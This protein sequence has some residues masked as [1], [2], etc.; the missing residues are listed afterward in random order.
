MSPMAKRWTM[1]EI[2]FL[3]K[4]KQMNLKE[5]MLNLPKRT[6]NSIKLKSMELF[7]PEIL[8]KNKEDVIEDYVNKKHGIKYIAKKYNVGATCLLH[9]LNNWKIKIR[10]RS[11]RVDMTGCNNKNWSGYKGIH[12]AMYTNIKRDANRRDIEFLVSIE[13]LWKLYVKQNKKCAISGE[14]I[15]ISTNRK[16]C[17]A[18]LDRKDYMKGYTNDNIQWVHKTVNIMKNRF[19]DDEF[20]LWCSKI[21]D[22]QKND[23]QK[24]KLFR[25]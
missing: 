13:Y 2:E 7:G 18:S 17:T 5:L 21:N 8:E 24:N 22:Y 4:N 20:I 16:L 1:K 15:N 25:L 12:G 19:Q 11:K 3:N 14:L 10:N 6:E 9:S 23:Y